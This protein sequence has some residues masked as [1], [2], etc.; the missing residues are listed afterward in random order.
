V[1]EV[2]GAVE[3]ALGRE[4]APP[5]DEV[6]GAA[7]LT[8]QRVDAAQGFAKLAIQVW[9]EAMRTPA[10]AG[11]IEVGRCPWRARPAGADLPGPRADGRRHAARA[12]RAGPRRPASRPR[13]PACLLGDVDPGAFRAGLRA[14][15]ATGLASPRPAGATA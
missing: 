9:G 5:L 6:L 14:L 7:F 13:V 4:D 10:L 15:L 11:I 3:T 8:I 1:T 12:G 2:A